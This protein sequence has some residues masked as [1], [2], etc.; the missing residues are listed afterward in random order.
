MSDEENIPLSSFNINESEAPQ[1]QEKFSRAPETSSTDF[2]RKLLNFWRKLSNFWGTSQEFRELPLSS[3]K[4]SRNPT[5]ESS[6]NLYGSSPNFSVCLHLGKYTNLRGSFPSFWERS[7]NFQASLLNS[8]RR[9]S[10]FRRHVSLHKPT[11]FCFRLS[12]NDW[13][14]V[15]EKLRGS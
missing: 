11:G 12:G 13:V 5:W 10:N 6:P 7:L 8:G 3:K 15:A 14:S 1:L 4:I 2:W 9:F